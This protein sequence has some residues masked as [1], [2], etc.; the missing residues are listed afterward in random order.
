MMR[1]PADR[2]HDWNLSPAEAIA[3]Q[4]QLSTQVVTAGDLTHACTVAGVDVGFEDGGRLTRAAVTV[5]SLAELKPVEMKIARLPTS[6][7]YVPGLLSFRELPAVLAAFDSISIL[8]DVVL[9]DGQG[10]AH[11]RR[12]GLACHLGVLL[13]VPSVG[14]GKSRLVGKHAEV[15]RGRGEQ[16]PLMVGDECIGMVLRTRRDVRP[17]FISVGHRT[18]L[19][20][21]V[22]LVLRCCTRYRLPEPIR[23]AHAAASRCRE[24]R[25]PDLSGA[26]SW[27]G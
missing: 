22:A 17:L 6:F 1:I 25:S 14:V 18:S 9:C 27:Q 7:P 3:L 12:F 5:F 15:G 16:V 10:I 2:L 20:H 23:A 21:A 4:R 19:P 8:P 24:A 11:P 13:D 26:G